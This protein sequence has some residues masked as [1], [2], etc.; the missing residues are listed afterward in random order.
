MYRRKLLAVSAICIFATTCW[1]S[2]PSGVSSVILADGEV[3]TSI[4]GLE[5]AAVA[6]TQ[7]AEKME[8][9]DN[10]DVKAVNGLQIVEKGTI[11]IGT[12]NILSI[13]KTDSGP[14][15]HVNFNIYNVY[16]DGKK[17]EDKTKKILTRVKQEWLRKSLHGTLAGL[18]ILAL[19]EVDQL[20]EQAGL[21]EQNGFEG[22]SVKKL[23]VPYKSS[24][25]IDPG[26][27]LLLYKTAL[28]ADGLFENPICDE[29]LAQA[30]PPVKQK[31]KEKG[32]FFTCTFKKKAASKS[33]V[34]ITGHAPSSGMTADLWEGI[35]T[36]VKQDIGDAIKIA[37]G[38]F[39]G[40]TSQG[41]N[42]QESA[43]N[44]ANKTESDAQEKLKKVQGNGRED[45]SVDESV[46]EAQEAV[47]EAVTAKQEVQRAKTH[48]LEM[49]KKLNFSVP[50]DKQ[51]T[52]KANVFILRKIA[53]GI[54]NTKSFSTMQNWTC[55]YYKE[56][57]STECPESPD[58]AVPPKRRIA[59][60]KYA[61]RFCN[62]EPDDDKFDANMFSRAGLA[63]NLDSASPDDKTIKQ[64]VGT[65]V[66]KS[67]GKTD[68][69]QEPLGNWWQH[70]YCTDKTCTGL[71]PPGQPFDELS[72]QQEDYIFSD[73]Q[74][75]N[76]VV[77]GCENLN[78]EVGKCP[79]PYVGAFVEAGAK[80][81]YET[82]LSA[83]E[84][85]NE[86]LGWKALLARQQAQDAAEKRWK[87]AFQ[88][89]H[90]FDHSGTLIPNDD[91]AK[92]GSSGW[93]SDHS[94]VWAEFSLN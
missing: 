92:M 23:P 71:T 48:C 84:A 3:E 75:V 10:Q 18:D 61:E 30:E 24:D 41:C 58:Q 47:A 83:A 60:C 91:F 5:E 31:T 8:A 11:K 52:T 37:M 90:D 43:F 79:G 20:S 67:L 13:A 78:D 36:A 1:T 19:H 33:L 22:W 35:N 93:L 50:I 74:A 25:D 88:K 49:M 53:Q 69:Y 70:I 9:K 56:Q 65:A 57:K 68:I 28:I 2:R 26:Y 66:N 76:S 39:N 44:K 54:F 89:Q 12:L 64:L 40:P 34:V 55:S 63:Y 81:A 45:A 4:S 72:Q 7:V 94:L 62:M 82:A 73:R 27:S 21:S 42:A 86:K 46:K 32:W 51:K 16:Q 15:G 17:D 14:Q 59:D 29:V 38:D 6:E 85:A 80:S 77:W 87:E